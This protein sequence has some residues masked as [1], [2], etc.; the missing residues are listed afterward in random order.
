[1]RN[2]YHRSRRLEDV[3]ER[4]AWRPCWCVMVDMEQI[5][6]SNTRKNGWFNVWT[7]KTKNEKTNQSNK[8]TIVLKTRSIITIKISE[9]DVWKLVVLDQQSNTVWVL[10]WCAP[11]NEWVNHC[12]ERRKERIYTLHF[13]P[14]SSDWSSVFCLCTQTVDGDNGDLGSRVSWVDL[15]RSTQFS[16]FSLSIHLFQLNEWEWNRVKTERNM[17]ENWL[18]ISILLQISMSLLCSTPTW[19]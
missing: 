19:V 11:K 3:E 5:R 1:M 18:K 16:N 8:Q 7:K 12:N 9:G 4:L 10:T 6:C 15:C 13:G 2:K 17:T 14:V